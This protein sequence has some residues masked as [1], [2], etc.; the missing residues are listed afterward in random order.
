MFEE[1]DKVTHS[2]QQSGLA[3]RPYIPLPLFQ[4]S[5]N[6]Q[7]GGSRSCL[8]RSCHPYLSLNL[9]GRS[10]Q[11]LLSAL[12][13]VSCFHIYVTFGHFSIWRFD[14][15]HLVDLCVHAKR[16]NQTDVWSFWRFEGQQDGHSVSMNV[17]NL[18]QL[19]HGS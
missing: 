3:L 17:T 13:K 16:G 8:P 1:R 6:H 10:L 4:E 18:C 2:D 5:G 19:F 11:Y 12:R 15:T 7:S 9:T 14:K